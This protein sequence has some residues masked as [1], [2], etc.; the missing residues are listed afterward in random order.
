MLRLSINFKNI[1]INRI[2]KRSFLL[3]SALVVFGQEIGKFNLALKNA[4][5]RAYFSSKNVDYNGMDQ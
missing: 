3:I 1:N 2:D 4:I 5:S